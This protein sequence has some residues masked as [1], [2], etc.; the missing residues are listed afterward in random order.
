[1]NQ[2]RTISTI[3]ATAAAIVALVAVAG[4]QSIETR[5][6]WASA[7]T[8][9]ELRSS[10]SSSTPVNAVSA[11]S[12]QARADAS[13]PCGAKIKKGNNIYSP[14]VGSWLN[15]VTLTPASGGQ[16]QFITM[17]TFNVAG[18]M[19]DEAEGP[20]DQES[21][22]IGAWSGGIHG[23]AASFEVF[24]YVSGQ[25]IGRVRVR[26]SFHVNAQDQLV[27]PKMTADFITVDGDVICSVA[28]ATLTGNRIP[29]LTP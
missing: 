29:A 17:E 3:A 25:L 22:G 23:A 27:A 8:T 28:T 18:T 2:K 14:L 19:I 12:A 16:R 11:A 13:D 26:G 9:S 5:S 7:L 20:G 24:E 1:M 4:A 15:T 10:S 21:V 6:G